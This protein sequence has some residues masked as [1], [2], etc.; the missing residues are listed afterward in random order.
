MSYV[1]EF[2][3]RALKSL[4]KMNKSVSAM[5]FAWIKKNLDKTQNPRV[6]GKA[7]TGGLSG[8][9][10]YRIGDYRII[11]EISDAKICIII[12]DIGHRGKIYD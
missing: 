4:K 2:S 12:I 5:L 8:L 6:H 10:R 1:V 7:L 9:W 11:A 3:E